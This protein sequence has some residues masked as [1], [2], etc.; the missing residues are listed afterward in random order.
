MERTPTWTPARVEQLTQLWEDGLIARDI[1]TK[2][3]GYL[4]RNMVIGKANRLGLTPRP[5]WRGGRPYGSR[6]AWSGTDLEMLAHLWQ[7]NVKTREIRDRISPTLKLR[8][9]SDKA[10]SLGLTRPVFR[11]ARTRPVF[12]TARKSRLQQERAAIDFSNPPF[13]DRKQIH[14]LQTDD[15]RWP[16]GDPRSPDFRYCGRE[17][18]H[19]PY[20]KP[21]H[22]IG[23]NE[24]AR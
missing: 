7:K 8:H 16:T 21:H 11:A 6:F 2:M 23:H 5:E 24:A 20:C 9:V 18:T 17:A 1:C 4:T 13:E 12:R 14:Q 22:I 3:G 10:R 19:G 15:C